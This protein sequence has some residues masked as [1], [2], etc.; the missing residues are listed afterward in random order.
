MLLF[1]KTKPCL[2]ILVVVCLGN[3]W[4]PSPFVSLTEDNRMAGPINQANDGHQGKVP[5]HCQVSLWLRDKLIKSGVGAIWCPTV[6]CL[7]PYSSLPLSPCPSVSL[8]Q[9]DLALE[10][11]P[12]CILRG[13]RYYPIIVFHGQGQS[14]VEEESV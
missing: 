7:P 4:R 13:K 11:H 3:M 5:T 14:R 8:C 9:H 6:F 2:A 10:Y 1:R 12:S